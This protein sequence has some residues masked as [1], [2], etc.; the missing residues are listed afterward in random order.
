MDLQSGYQ[1]VTTSDFVR[2][3]GIWQEQARD[4]PVYIA[5]RGRPKCVLLFVEIMEALCDRGE[6]TDV[7]ADGQVAALIDSYDEA[8]ILFDDEAIITHTNRAA[9]ARFAFAIEGQPIDGLL[10]KGNVFIASLV[11]RVLQS[12]TS[13]HLQVP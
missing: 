2:Q 12:G 13:E 4:E 7:G 9:R 3:F 5:H 11:K 8:V 10:V 1:Q 6:L